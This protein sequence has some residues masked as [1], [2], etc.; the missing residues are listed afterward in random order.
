M[1][2]QERRG[3]FY[4][5][6]SKNCISP[7]YVFL[8]RT[9]QVSVCAPYLSVICTPHNNILAFDPTIAFSSRLCLWVD[10]T[11]FAA[12]QKAKVENVWKFKKLWRL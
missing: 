5:C 6:L 8:S 3:Y 12:G 10:N 4:N 11:V 9:A 1:H 7:M 2:V